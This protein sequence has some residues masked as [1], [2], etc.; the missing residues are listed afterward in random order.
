MIKIYLTLIYALTFYFIGF[1]M[2]QRKSEYLM[3]NANRK[4]QECINIIKDT[5]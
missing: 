4:L 2:G 1:E 3:I 5:K